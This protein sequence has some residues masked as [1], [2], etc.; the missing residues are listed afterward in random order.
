MSEENVN[1]DMLDNEVVPCE[2]VQQSQTAMDSAPVVQDPTHSAAAT[3]NDLEADGKKNS[4]NFDPARCLKLTGLPTSLSEESPTAFTDAVVEIFNKTFGIPSEAIEKVVRFPVKAGSDAVPQEAAVQALIAFRSRVHK[5][6]VF[7]QRTKIEAPMSIDQVNEWPGELT[8]A[9]E[10]EILASSGDF[11]VCDEVG[12]DSDITYSDIVAGPLLTKT[13]AKHAT[14]KRQPKGK[15]DSAAKKAD[16]AK[17]GEAAEAVVN[18]SS[19]ETAAGATAAESNAAEPTEATAAAADQKLV[20]EEPTKQEKGEGEK[21]NR[22]RGRSRSP[23][24]QR[25]RGR[26]PPRASAVAAAKISLSADSIQPSR[27]SSTATV[28]FSYRMVVVDR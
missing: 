18:G 25:K 24:R 8:A 23:G 19:T 27:P 26:G 6:R 1:N 14:N 17:A 7:T 2:P 3:E 22:K 11:V 16:G 15:D 12:E 21:D 20:K 10:D 4:A 13:E 5:H 28:V 9:Q